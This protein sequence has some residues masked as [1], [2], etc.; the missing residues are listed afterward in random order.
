MVEE[1]EKEYDKDSASDYPTAFSD[2]ANFML[3]HAVDLNG[4]SRLLGM[5]KVC[6]LLFAVLHFAVLLSLH[7]VAIF[8]C[9]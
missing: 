8:L 7:S 5:I 6:N 1:D 3:Q 2:E 4:Q 9:V